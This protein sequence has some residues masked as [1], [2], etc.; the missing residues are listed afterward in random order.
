MILPISEN[1]T[2]VSKH[3]VREVSDQL[4]FDDAWDTFYQR[5]L[6]ITYPVKWGLKLLHRWRLILNKY[7][8]HTLY[9]GCNYLSTLGFKLILVSKS[10]LCC[11]AH[12]WY[13]LT[14]SKMTPAE[15]QSTRLK[16][17]NSHS[18]SGG[19]LAVMGTISVMPKWIVSMD[20]IVHIIFKSLFSKLCQSLKTESRHDAE[21]LVIGST[22]GCHK[23][24]LWYRHWWQSW[25]L[26]NTLFFSEFW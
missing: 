4:I 16:L 8:H 6:V 17:S 11:Y 12:D 26:D 3:L 22:T 5:E 14:K 23:D 19:I 20:K 2:L 15:Y 13:N 18:K 10:G 21:F 24:N 25:H 9:N 1:H 7:F